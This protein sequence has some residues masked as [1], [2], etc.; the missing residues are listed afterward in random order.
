[1]TIAQPHPD[2]ALRATTRWCFIGLV[3]FGVAA[4]FFYNQIANL[5]QVV[6]T[7]E[8]IVNQLEEQNA[9][10]KNDVYAV[11]DA[12]TVAEEIA[13]GGYVKDGRP[14]FLAFDASGDLIRNKMTAALK[15]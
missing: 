12:R 2:S 4:V 11:L 9:S 7:R 1:M 13:H 5:K 8:K 14:Q 15:P 3:L 10:L 6:A